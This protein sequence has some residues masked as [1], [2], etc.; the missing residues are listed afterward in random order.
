MKIERGRRIGE[1]QGQIN[2]SYTRIR[3][4]CLVNTGYNFGLFSCWDADAVNVHGSVF[5]LSRF[6]GRG[7]GCH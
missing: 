7:R 4:S 1:D 3:A 2:L 6:S 5:G